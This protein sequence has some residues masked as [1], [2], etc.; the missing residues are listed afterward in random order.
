MVSRGKVG[1]SQHFPTNLH[2]LLDEAEKANHAH[3]VSWC[4]QGHSFKIH[5]QDALVPLLAKYFRQ[6]K[7]KS[8]L[9][10]LQ[11]YGFH[12]TTRGCDKGTVS[13]PFF[14]RG[15]RSLCFR[16]TRKPTGASQQAAVA[17]ASTHPAIPR[18]VTNNMVYQ[19]PTLPG[20]GIQ[21]IV[22]KVNSEP[23]YQNTM[24]RTVTMN[25][26][27]V[28]N[29]VSK[30]RNEAF[31]NPMGNQE[32]GFGSNNHHA[33]NAGMFAKLQPPKR[34]RSSSNDVLGRN[35]MKFNINKMR[36]ASDPVVTMTAAQR[37]SLMKCAEV[38]YRV[39]SSPP[40]QAPLE[41]FLLS[42]K[43]SSPSNPEADEVPSVQQQQV[44]FQVQRGQHQEQMPQA[45]PQDQSFVQQVQ[46]TQTRGS[47]NQVRVKY[48]AYPDADLEPVPVQ[49]SPINSNAR[50]EKV[51]S[52]QEVVEKIN[53]AKQ[54]MEK[55][56][57]AQYTK[58]GHQEP[59]PIPGYC[60]S[61]HGIQGHQYSHQEQQQQQQ[62][63]D[64][65]GMQK[66]KDPEQENK[67]H[68]AH[69][70]KQE[71]LPFAGTAH[72]VYDQQKSDAYAKDVFAMHNLPP[73]NFELSFS[74]SELN[75]NNNNNKGKEEKT[76]PSREGNP[77]GNSSS[78]SLSISSGG[79]L[80]SLNGFARPMPPVC[81]NTDSLQPITIQSDHNNHEKWQQQQQQFHPAA[82][83]QRQMEDPL[84]AA[85]DPGQCCKRS[86]NSVASTCDCTDEGTVD[87]LLQNGAGG[88]EEWEMKA[89]EVAEGLNYYG[90]LGNNNDTAGAD[91]APTEQCHSDP[92]VYHHNQH[93]DSTPLPI[94]HV[95]PGSEQTFLNNRQ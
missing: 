55:H 52:H 89:E 45:L 16:M 60:P 39:D 84:S 43:E 68:Q 78:F 32:D 64:F 9:R 26:P 81:D 7:F 71:K 11:S 29:E 18:T 86:G 90:F 40:R 79:G 62:Q 41:S 13:H 12:R 33:L 58:T 72:P 75:V 27:G 63:V 51:F 1:N 3:I 91:Q 19:L 25:G 5:D 6:T 21:P 83:S 22:R 31:G 14:V 85:N 53:Q 10:Q 47:Q 73:T 92:R 74:T 95:H 76:I 48:Q 54:D 36:R 94:H 15:R 66:H 88:C 46:V 57:R 80:P 38:D 59:T 82:F 37:E 20:N 35:R 34:R 77:V 28:Y 8:F 24:Q 50:A 4:S 70:H 56:F 61:G 23:M 44:L 17:A 87:Y 69:L 65:H 42:I 93:H 49:H 2:V 67:H 30:M